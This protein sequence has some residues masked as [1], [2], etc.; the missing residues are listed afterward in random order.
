[1]EGTTPCFRSIAHI[2]THDPGNYYQAHFGCVAYD[3]SRGALSYGRRYKA[4]SETNLY[5]CC[6]D[7][8][9]SFDLTATRHALL[10][11]LML[12][13]PDNF[14]AFAQTLTCDKH[15]YDMMVSWTRSLW[16]KEMACQDRNWSGFCTCCN[17]R[18]PQ[19]RWDAG[20][21]AEDRELALS[22]TA[23][24]I[25]VPNHA[26]QAQEVTLSPDSVDDNEDDTAQEKELGL[27]R[28]SLSVVSPP[29]SAMTQLLTDNVSI[30]DITVAMVSILA[31][32]VVALHMIRR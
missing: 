5:Q 28:I 22:I 23:H 21:S 2:I 3:H 25:P 26:T 6:N 13:T 32:A 4:T 16:F 20:M 24:R 29:G 8:I 31:S 17:T 11:T 18:K 15:R 7:E 10:K 1:M 27:R 30:R 9:T 19:Y 12:Q 14:E